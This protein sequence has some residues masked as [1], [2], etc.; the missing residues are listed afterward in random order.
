MNTKPVRDGRRR[1]RDYPL[2]QRGVDSAELRTRLTRRDRR[3][4]INNNALRPIAHG[5]YSPTVDAD[6]HQLHI[7]ALQALTRDSACLVS[8]ETA[9]ILLGLL[10]GPLAPP[11]HI[12]TPRRGRYVQH[13]LVTGHR[14]DVPAAHRVKFLRIR[15]TSPA[16]T[17]TDLA[18]NS[19]LIE[20]LVLADKTIRSGRPEFGERKAPLATREHLRAALK[21]RKSANGVRTAAQALELA[22]EG[23]DSP[24]ETR[25]RFC[26]FEAG[27]PEPEVNAWLVDERGRRVVQPDLALRQWKLAIQY[28]G[29]EYHTDP[30][31]MAKD[32]RRQERTEALGWIE[33][34]ITREHLRN[35]GAGAIEKI[36]RALLRQGWRP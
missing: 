13:S 15:T 29:W 32:I 12:T 2:P 26:M 1:R 17:W 28:E 27:L 7:D 22:R 4:A 10:E 14:S 35:G 8:H 23:V 18:L 20:A 31:Q 36:R 25:L 11:F 33:V 16:W 19:S 24:Q 5:L 34:R 9:G 30:G 21:R 3:H 6:E